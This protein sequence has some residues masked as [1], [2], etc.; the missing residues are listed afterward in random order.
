[1]QAAL[2]LEN[3]IWYPYTLNKKTVHFGCCFWRNEIA[4]ASASFWP[5]IAKKSF[6]PISSTLAPTVQTERKIDKS[7]ESHE[8]ELIWIAARKTK[9]RR[10]LKNVTFKFDWFLR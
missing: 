8:S 6:S 3:S 2:T 9:L 4:K 10:Y 7:G 5:K 1:M